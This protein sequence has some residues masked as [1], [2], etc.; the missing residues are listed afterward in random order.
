MYSDFILGTKT[1]TYNF[2]FLLN[3]SPITLKISVN[4]KYEHSQAKTGSQCFCYANSFQWN[5]AFLFVAHF[6]YHLSGVL[7]LR[8]EFFV[9][10]KYPRALNK[11]KR[12]L[13]WL[14]E[15]KVIYRGSCEQVMK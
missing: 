5:F 1:A 2:D 15:K 11:S 12:K 8:S 7:F 3:Y 14:R 6:A 10:N 13:E 9:N 4:I